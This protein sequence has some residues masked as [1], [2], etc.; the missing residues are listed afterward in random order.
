MPAAS[1]TGAAG[2][3]FQPHHH[4]STK[5][6]CYAYYRL[7][8]KRA[9]VIQIRCPQTLELVPAEELVPFRALEKIGCHL[10]SLPSGATVLITRAVAAPILD[11]LEE[12][13]VI[14]AIVGG[15]ITV[16]KAAPCGPQFIG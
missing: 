1:I 2:F 10:G 11:Q 4:M 12:M 8:N 5:P 3:S 7:S 16:K 14:E 13:P 9:V 15:K 6:P